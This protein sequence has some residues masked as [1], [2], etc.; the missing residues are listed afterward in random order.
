MTDLLTHIQ[1]T[2]A[3]LCI[4]LAMHLFSASA[5]RPFPAR[6]LGL[7]FLLFATQSILLIGVLQGTWLALTLL[8]PC[9][10]MILAPVFYL[11][12]QSV[13]RA[14]AK[15]NWYDC[16]HFLPA[17]IVAMLFISKSSLRLYIDVC[18]LSSYSV[19]LLLVIIRLRH[20]VS[21]LAHLGE[22][23]PLAFRWLALLAMLVFINICLELGIYFEMET[24]VAL[25]NAKT[26]LVGSVIFT[27]VNAITVFA[28]LKR[29]A[30]I[31]WMYEFGGRAITTVSRPALSEAESKLLFERWE[32]I[33]LQEKVYLKEFGIT[34]TEAAKKLSVPVR[35][36]SNAVNQTY[37]G[38]FSQHLNGKRVNEVI[39]LFK[40]Q[41][42]Q[43][44]TTLMLQAGFNT[45]S[46][47]NKEFSRIMGTSPSEYRKLSSN[48]AGNNQKN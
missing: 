41:P 11:Y 6:L 12:S 5:R 24:G 20:G 36:L 44:I 33:V 39:R 38:S 32:N 31:E 4:I 30:M 7:N 9:I 45:K 21:A 10:A 48:I 25:A 22:Y 1:I 3:F 28:S 34:L 18:I 16:L 8:R 13:C 46:N 35:H 27:L 29:I 43:P 14:Q 23:A 26:L 15:L 37:G 40:Q 47:F 42:E 2:N 19:Y 17:L